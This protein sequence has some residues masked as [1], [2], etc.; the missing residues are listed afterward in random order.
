MSGNFIILIMVKFLLFKV[1]LLFVIIQCPP[2]SRD[3]N[4]DYHH[5]YHD[6]SP[7]VIQIFIIFFIE[8]EIKMISSIAFLRT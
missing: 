2:L 6:P 3:D 1:D 5:L 8:K 4:N 7:Y